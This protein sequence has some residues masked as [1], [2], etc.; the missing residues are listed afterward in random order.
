MKYIVAAGDEAGDV[1]FRFGRGSSDFFVFALVFTEDPERLREQL[2]ALKKKLK[3]KDEEEFKFFKMSN[4]RRA[5]FFKEL[6]SIKYVVR[7]IAVDKRS[8]G[9]QWKVL[10]KSVFLSEVVSNL[11]NSVGEAIMKN[12]ILVLDEFDEA[13]RA[14]LRIRQKLRAIGAPAQR[15]N[16]RSSRSE[17]LIQMADMCAGAIMRG[18]QSKKFFHAAE[19]RKFE[20]IK[21]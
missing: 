9:Q 7:A 8:L 14:E 13:G 18:L 15:V 12:C 4:S 11:A 17:V 10:D 5:E 16:A 1:G 21:F 6:Y 19:M 20:V 3:M 2:I